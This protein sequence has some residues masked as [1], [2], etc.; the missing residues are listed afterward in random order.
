M[1]TVMRMM[2]L[3]YAGDN[4]RMGGGGAMQMI[5]AA[6]TS[7]QRGHGFDKL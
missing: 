7:G 6:M 5:A 1:I 3:K 4:D 2:V